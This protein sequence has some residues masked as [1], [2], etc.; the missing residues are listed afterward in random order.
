MREEG[1]G[2]SERGK[3]ASSGGETNGREGEAEGQRSAGE[4]PLTEAGGEV[5]AGAMSGRTDAL[6]GAVG[7]G[8]DAA[9]AEVLLAAL[10]HVCGTASE[11]AAHLRGL[12]SQAKPLRRPCPAPLADTSHSF[13]RPSYAPPFPA[14]PT[15]PTGSGP[16][17]SNH[18][19]TYPDS[20][21]S[22]SKPRLSLAAARR[23]HNP[24][25]DFDA[26]RTQS[27]NSDSAFRPLL[28]LIFLV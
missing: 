6:E 22:P 7:V 2:E 13:P 3:G 8:T 5:W 15:P 19:A 12:A 21:P 11:T 1:S 4:A 26:L 27:K 16:A 23:L 14:S 25:F 17:P 24:G 18:G 20:A 28:V 9:L 10:V